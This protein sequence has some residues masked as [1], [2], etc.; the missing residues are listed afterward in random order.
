M[1]TRTAVSI[2]L[3]VLVWLLSLIIIIPLLLVLLSSLKDR[4]GASLM[5]LSL[6]KIFHF[7]NYIQVIKEGSL[8]RSFVNSLLITTGSVVVS[9]AAS[10]MASFVLSRNRTKRNN[11][12]YYYFLIGLIAPINMIT[13]IRTLQFIHLMN[14]YP[15]I[16]LLYSALLMS[17]SVFLYY[18]FV[19]TVPR[20]LDES[21]FIDGSS[22]I[23]LFLR[24]VFPLLK[25]V[26]F[27][28]MVINFMGAWNNFIIPL[29]VLNRSNMW[30]MTLAIYNFY[31]WRVSEWQ[32]VNADVI[33][34][35]APVVLLYIIGQRYIISGM[36]AGAIKG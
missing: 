25:P 30:P 23:D 16:I 7:E 24:I 4:A 17:F 34:T 20:E 33:L 3:E 8:L 14:T 9:I 15:G 10:S 12:I 11:G 35:I 2:F 19:N 28:I 21:A 26:T 29:Y 32:L 31:G 13:V 18:G 6:P 27:T 5:S 1:K 36:T 22:S